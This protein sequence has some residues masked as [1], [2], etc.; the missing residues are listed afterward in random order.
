MF[1]KINFGLLIFLAENVWYEHPKNTLVKAKIERY[2]RSVRCKVLI[3]SSTSRTFNIN[4]LS[5]Q[6]GGGCGKLIFACL[7]LIICYVTVLS[8][9]IIESLQIIIVNIIM[10]HKNV[11]L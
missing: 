6:K 1:T 2:Q 5:L 3:S 9:Y 8:A 4:N 10:H 7:L 11:C